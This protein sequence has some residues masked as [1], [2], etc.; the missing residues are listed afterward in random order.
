MIPSRLSILAILWAICGLPFGTA[1]ADT[2]FTLLPAGGA[3]SGP[4]GSAVGWG[5]DMT[6]GAYYVAIDSVTITGETSPVG[7]TSG[8]FVAYMPLLSGG[9]GD[10]VTA[11][12]QEWMEA[13]AQGSPGSGLGEYDIDPGTAVGASDS[14]SFVITYDEFSGDP[15]SCGSCYVDTLTMNLPGGGLPAFTIDVTSP[16]APVPE[17]SSAVLVAVELA[18]LAMAAV[19]G[20]KLRSL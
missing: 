1:R 12:G 2:A 15:N 16:A 17:P 4:A 6:A 8:G 11:P 14:G 18:V 3:V 10:G 9:V 7:G 13:F 20:N 19:F 5:F